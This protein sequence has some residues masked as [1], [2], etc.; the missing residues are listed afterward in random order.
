MFNKYSEVSEEWLDI[1]RIVLINKKPRRL[2]VNYNLIKNS[3]FRY[4]EI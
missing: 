1:R 4:K 3:K 2:T